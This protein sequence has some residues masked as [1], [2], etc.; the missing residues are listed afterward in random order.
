[1]RIPWTSYTS[2]LV[3]RSLF[4]RP[5]RFYS[6]GSLSIDQNKPLKM[7]RC[8]RHLNKNTYILF[9]FKIDFFRFALKICSWHIFNE[10]REYI[11]VFVHLQH[12]LTVS[13]RKE[14]KL[15]FTF[16]NVPLISYQRKTFLIKAICILRI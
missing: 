10:T 7:F 3:G 13:Y 6:D 5:T 12:F 2:R 8:A 15:K 4:H 16:N 11:C 1:M 14:A 9:H